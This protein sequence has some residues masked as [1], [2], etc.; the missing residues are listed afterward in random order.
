MKKDYLEKSWGRSFVFVIALFLLIILGLIQ[1]HAYEK[2][3]K[4]AKINALV[5]NNL[6]GSSPMMLASD[7]TLSGMFLG[8]ENY[9][10]NCN[11]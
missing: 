3:M 6:I 5:K 8:L 7:N 2:V 10:K 1:P 11:S 4:S 9:Q